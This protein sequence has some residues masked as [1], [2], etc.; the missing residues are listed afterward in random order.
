M[1]WWDEGDAG[2]GEDLMIYLSGTISAASAASLCLRKTAQDR[3]R[4]SL[5]IQADRE[6][7]NRNCIE[8]GINAA[9]PLAARSQQS[10]RGRSRRIRTGVNESV[11]RRVIV[12]RPYCVV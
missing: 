9:D 7:A 8:C 12:C 5:R 4:D 10:E 6:C 2:S 11:D 3:T 1:E